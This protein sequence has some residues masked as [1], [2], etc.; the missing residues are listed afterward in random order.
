[1]HWID[2]IAES[3]QWAICIQGVKYV[4]I[5][6]CIYFKIDKITQENPVWMHNHPAMANSI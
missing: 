6:L 3:L 5:L 2:G 4:K 1:M